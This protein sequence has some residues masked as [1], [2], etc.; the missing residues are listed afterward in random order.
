MSEDRAAQNE[1][2]R[3][4][5]DKILDTT[6]SVTRVSLNRGQ[7]VRMLVE[8][9]REPLANATYGKNLRA[10]RLAKGWSM[11]QLGKRADISPAHINNLE[12]GKVVVDAAL[13]RRLAVAFD[14][15]PTWLTGPSPDPTADLRDQEEARE[16]LNRRARAG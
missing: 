16:Y 6:S 12:A 5:V 8:A 14:V 9:L 13:T 11:A 4:V 15:H 1:R 2:L 10:L 3:Q 7:I